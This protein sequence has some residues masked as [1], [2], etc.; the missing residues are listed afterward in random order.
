MQ[1]NGFVT[2]R[3]DAATQVEPEMMEV[4]QQPASATNARKA[5]LQSAHNLSFVRLARFFYLI[6]RIITAVSFLHKGNAPYYDPFC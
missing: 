4:H 2:N 3:K 5:M 1:A 6:E